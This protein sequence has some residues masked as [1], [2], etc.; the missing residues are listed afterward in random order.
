MSFVTG[1]RNKEKNKMANVKIT[2][3]P[4]S[5][6]YLDISNTSSTSVAIIELTLSTA[7]QDDE[8][9]LE[10]NGPLTG[11]IIDY[12]T[13]EQLGQTGYNTTIPDL[14]VPRLFAGQQAVDGVTVN[15]FIVI[16]Q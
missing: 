1:G 12:A 2:G 10:G 9:I 14:D 16:K 15:A 4:L 3:I 7:E 6:N 13:F 5:S 8:L 11:I